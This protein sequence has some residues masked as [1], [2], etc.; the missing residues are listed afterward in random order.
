MVQNIPF[1]VSVLSDPVS[2]LAEYFLRMISTFSLGLARSVR[3]GDFFVL[4]VSNLLK[5]EHSS[6]ISHSQ[7]TLLVLWRRKIRGGATEQQPL[8]ELNVRGMVEILPAELSQ[9]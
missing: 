9:C 5:C 8:M 3:G 7:L 1:C 2:D 4:C 6:Y